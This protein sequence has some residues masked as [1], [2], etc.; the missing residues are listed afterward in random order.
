[1]VLY[2]S[3]LHKT[4]EGYAVWHPALSRCWLQAAVAIEE[5]KQLLR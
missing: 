3:G 4:K 5:F 1:M 2:P